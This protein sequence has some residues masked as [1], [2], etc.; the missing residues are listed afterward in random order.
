MLSDTTT[1]KLHEM[2]LSVMA[3]SFRD[4]LK[5]NN[6][7]NMSFEERFG[8]LIDAEWCARKNNR[9]L[10]LI[11]KAEYPVNDACIENIEYHSD[12]NLDKV[13]LTR[14]SSC[15]YIKEY[16][17]IIILGATGSGKTYLA[18][19]LGMSASRNF[20][21]VKYV[22]L[23]ELLAELAISRSD[24]TYRKIIKQYKQVKLLIL[25]E[26]LLFPLKES[27]ARDLLEII[28][29]RCKKASTIFCSQFEVA[30]WYHKIGESTLADAICDRIVHDSYTIVIGGKDSMRKKKGIEIM[31]SHRDS[32]PNSGV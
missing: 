9:L 27:E 24:G 17:N 6:F 29:A 32:V 26:W 3:N 14:L 11:K 18:T 7:N 12:R 8:L 30:G 2:R 22:R 15:N 21:T 4:Q 13:Q 25:D 20:Y 16:H 1:N 19:A 10:R 28:E 5:D 23:P 31:A